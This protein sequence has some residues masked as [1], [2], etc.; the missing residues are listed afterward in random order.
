MEPVTRRSESVVGERCGEL[1]DGAACHHLSGK[2]MEARSD[3]CFARIMRV[4]DAAIGVTAVQS[5]FERPRI[6]SVTSLPCYDGSNDGMHGGLLFRECRISSE[7]QEF[8]LREFA[9]QRFRDRLR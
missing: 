6:E 9:R 3:L 4:L 7:M 8:G 2:A 5:R 1:V